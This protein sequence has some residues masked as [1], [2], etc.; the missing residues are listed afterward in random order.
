MRKAF[1]LIELLVVIAIIA[2]LAAILFPVFAQAKDSAKSASDLSNVKQLGIAVAMYTAD[3]NDLYPLGH[4]EGILSGNVVHGY[5]WYKYVP[6][7]W[8][9]TTSQD[10]R[11]SVSTTFVMNTI[12]PYVK[13]NQIMA[14]PGQAEY[15]YRGTEIVVPGKRK[16]TTTYSYNGVLQSYS[17]TAVAS[18]SSLPLFTEMNGNRVGVGVGFAIPALKCQ[19]TGPCSYIPRVY[20]APGVV[21]VGGRFSTNTHGGESRMYVRFQHADSSLW[22]YKRG[23][24]WTFTDSHAQYRAMGTIPDV[25][26]DHHLDPWLFYNNRGQS[27]T[28]WYDGCHVYLFRPDYEF[29]PE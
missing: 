6:Y 9:D 21:C 20:S 2:I 5:N 26:T 17:T 28:Y 22:L 4:G 24:N 13:N 7:D 15:V 10:F 23:Q 19:L 12:Q 18:I 27:N 3:N 11:K 1:T 16:G 14:S 8:S 29:P 25:E